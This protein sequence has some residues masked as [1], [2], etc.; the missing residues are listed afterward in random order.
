MSETIS[1]T[2]GMTAIRRGK[3]W[4][5]AYGVI[6]IIIGLLAFLWPFPATIAATIYVGAALIVAGVAA[7]ASGF[8]GDGHDSRWY[9]IL[10][11]LLTVVVGC[12]LAFRPVSGAVSL[13]LLVAIW[14]G[15][16]GVLEILWGIRHKHH[17]WLM[18]GMGALNIL[19]DILI[20]ATIPFTA[21]ILP[22]YILGLSFLMG[23]ITAI[24]IAMRLGEVAKAD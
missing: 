7:L 2:S 15:V 10:F 21:M 11:G 12:M 23:G 6:S 1:A 8:G 3:G 13:T 14:L 17:R 20:L 18:I 24:A 22:G 9:D 4:L 16:R 19:L 5:I